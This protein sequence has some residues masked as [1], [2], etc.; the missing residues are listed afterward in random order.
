M[1]GLSNSRLARAI[2]AVAVSLGVL[3]PAPGD[4]IADHGGRPIGALFACDRPVTPPRCTSVADNPRHLVYFDASLTEDLRA[5]MRD[6]MAVYGATELIVVEQARLTR[7]TDVIAFSQDYGD[8]GAAGW[9]YCPTDA[10]QG[11]NPVGDRWCRQQELHLNLNPR[12]GAFFADD[13]SRDHVTCHEMGHTVGLRHWGNPPQTSGDDVGATCMNANTPNGPTALH[14]I[15]VDHINGY[16]YRQDHP[17]RHRI[18]VS[19]PGAPHPRLV[20]WTGTLQATELD[21]PSS[22]TDLVQRSDAVVRGRIVEVRPGRVFGDPAS[23]LHYAAATL[24]VDELL[25]GATTSRTLTL[26][27]PLFDGPSSI[28]RLPAWGEA[29]FFLRNKGE[30]ARIAGMPADVQAA[31]APFHRLV[32]FSSIIVDHDGR[33]LVDT[34]APFAAEVAGLSFP[35]LVD[36][37]RS[38]AR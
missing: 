18:L 24:Q 23:A 31:E 28:D 15:D 34:E 38:L 33:A 12:Y 4:V 13:A 9:V 6:A 2:V 26:E 16:A 11:V 35:D 32:S 17:R 10:P 1:F 30:S 19:P 3:L 37:V 36:R 29:I 14:Q 20:P 22:L 5:S 8:N 25:A 27:I 21:A 7:M